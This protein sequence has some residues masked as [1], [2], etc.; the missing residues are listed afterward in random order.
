[1]EASISAEALRSAAAAGSIFPRPPLPPA[2][3]STPAVETPGGEGEREGG[4]AEELNISQLA[5]TLMVDLSAFG[6]VLYS[7]L[8][9][10]L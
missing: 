6:I 10:A 9:V 3:A 1:M 4:E 2:P 8:T 5:C 7:V